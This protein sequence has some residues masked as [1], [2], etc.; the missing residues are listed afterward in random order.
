MNKKRMIEKMNQTLLD[1][2][3]QI[4]DKLQDEV[5]FGKNNFEK[6]L[7]GFLT[8][9]ELLNRKKDISWA[10]AELLGEFYEYAPKYRKLS[11]KLFK[12]NKVIIFKNKTRFSEYEVF[13]S[14]LTL[15]HMM[16]DKNREVI[17]YDME[18]KEHFQ[19]EISEEIVG[20]YSLIL[21]KPSIRGLFAG[22]KVEFISRLNS[23]INEI[24]YGKIPKSIFEKFQENVNSLL[25]ESNPIAVSELNIAIESL[26]QSEDPARITHVAHA[27]KRLIR[28]IADE[29]FPDKNEKYKMKDGKEI[30]VGKEQYLNRLEAFVDDIDSENRKY[31]LKK[32][33]L[34]R[35]LY[36]ET[37]ES[38]NKGTHDIIS[39]KSAELAVIYSY[40]ILGEIIMEKKKE[41]I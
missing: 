19:K 3:L 21:T 41:P 17:E 6:N 4:A 35:D 23:M 40:I 15:E 27:C 2:G 36:G 30:Q 31:L 26:G 13:A 24:T 10:K 29:V 34:L 7:H 22:A 33:K 37:P 5:L 38:I 8:V 28:S 18:V 39:N 32:L 16:E 9:A 1:R 20:Q 12:N 11:C 14:L 25:A